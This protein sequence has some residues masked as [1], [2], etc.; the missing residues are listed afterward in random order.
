[1]SKFIDNNNKIRRMFKVCFH[2]SMLQ[3]VKFLADDDIL[4]GTHRQGI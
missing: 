4:D 3:A 2:V 1:M